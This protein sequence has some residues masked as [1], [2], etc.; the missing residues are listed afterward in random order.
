MAEFD[1]IVGETSAK[2]NVYCRYNEIY[3]SKV[4]S[5]EY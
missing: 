3:K 2:I 4:W 5:V 1:Q